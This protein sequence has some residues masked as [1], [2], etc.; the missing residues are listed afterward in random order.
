MEKVA[1]KGRGRPRKDLSVSVDIVE[2]ESSPN[3]D[4]GERETGS[5]GFEAQADVI[6]PSKRFDWSELV[7]YVIKHNRR[8]YRIMCAF[9]PE[10]SGFIE[11][12]DLGNIRTEKGDVAIELNTGEIIKL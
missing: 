12:Q 3:L 1:G 10:A 8:D 4:N 5:T 11:T 6:R 9:H 2:G 7:D